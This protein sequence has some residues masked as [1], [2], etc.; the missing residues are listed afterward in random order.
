LAQKFKYWAPPWLK[1]RWANTYVS[2]LML[3]SNVT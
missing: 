2:Q 1:S 3:D